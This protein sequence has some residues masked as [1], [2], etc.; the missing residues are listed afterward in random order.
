MTPLP[1]SQCGSVRYAQLLSEMIQA[2][3][4]LVSRPAIAVPLIIFLSYITYQLFIKPSNLPDLP[5]IGARK[6]DWFPLFQ[7]RIR[8]S[9]NVKAVLNSSYAQYKNQA[10]ILPLLDGGNIILLPRSDTKF[11]SEQPTDQLSMHE[12]AQH[13]LQTD[14]TTMT[15]S[16]THDP[17]HLDLVLTHLTKEVGNLIPDLAE[18]IEH[19]VRQQWGTSS[20]WTEVCIFENAQLI[21]SGVTNR[22]FVGFPLCRNDEMLKLGIAF[23]QDIPLSSM[24]LK[25]FPNFLKPL[26]APIIALPNRIHNNKFERILKPEIQARLAKYDAQATEAEKPPKSERN[27][28]LQWLIEQAKDI[29]HP[30]NWK[31]N[32]LSERVLMMNFASIHTTTFAVTHTLLDIAASSPGL[33]AEL[34][35]EIKSVLEQHDGK[36]NKRAVAKLEKLDSAIRESQRKNSIVSVAVSRTVVA[37]KGVTFPSGTHVPKGLRIAVPG[38]SVF[39]DPEVYPEPKKYNALRFY[40]ARQNEKDEYVKTCASFQ[41]KDSNV[42]PGANVECAL[43]NAWTF[44]RYRH[45]TLGSSIE[46]S[47]QA[48]TWE[49]VYRPFQTGDDI[50]SWLN[51]TF[52]I[53]ETDESALSWFNNYAPSFHMPMV[54]VVQSGLEAQQTVFLRCPHDITDGVGILQLLD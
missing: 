45:P 20:E 51:S 15:P 39:Q 24:L 1:S 54:Y 5:I 32:A 35:D 44:L 52:K 40:N 46:G 27:D 31:V 30:K 18:E 36:W 7:A 22:A 53:I 28:Y 48:D 9:L 50:E 2:A 4:D 23:A 10:T 14:W 3:T 38:Y 47:D 21:T 11:A 29:G 6:S 8:N 42:N 16:L 19:C 49:R 25:P 43:R 12:S 41:G 34:R 13:D 26:V 17:I 33:I 37:E